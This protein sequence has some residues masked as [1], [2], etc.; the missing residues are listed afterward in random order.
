MT[1]L[2]DFL[3]T[4][5]P[6]VAK[7]FT[8]AIE[9][10]TEKL[11]TA[12]Y[13]LNKALNGG[14]AK[15]HITLLYGNTSSSKTA[16]MLQS[17]AKWQKMGQVCAFVDAEGTYSK[18]W[19]ERLGVNNDELILIRRRSFGRITDEMVPLLE[20]EIDVIV[21]DSISMALPEV[22]V[23]KE[24]G[25]VDF[26]DMKQMGAHAKSCTIMT[27]AIHYANESTA[28]VLI[29]Q[30]T[31]EIGQTYTKQI[32]HGGKKILFASSQII[33]LSSSAT[34]ANQIKG[35]TY[36]GDFIIERAIGRPVNGVVEKNKLGPQSRTF[37]YD[38]YYD[39]GFVGI[40]T[41]GE[42]VDDAVAYSIIK[43]GGAWFSFDDLKWQGRPSVVAALRADAELES[44][45]R[46]QIHLLET[47][48]VVD[49]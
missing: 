3:A 44:L 33:K 47:G 11:P 28:V 10:K 9:S 25:V 15:G 14:I 13:R 19:A 18:E 46:K 5:S 31:T 17:I 37:S 21:V 29:S 36:A 30:T 23:D 20:A 26:K 34:D 22:F 4:L 48:E 1:R 12:S 16:L 40:D 42:I 41:I 8:T 49:E 6:K 7:Q 35:E 38:F 45:I 2:D 24:G 32:P 43:K 39:G 27:N